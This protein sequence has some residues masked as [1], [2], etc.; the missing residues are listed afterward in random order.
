MSSPQ[1]G[2]R[3]PQVPG[4]PQAHTYQQYLAQKQAYAQMSKQASPATVWVDRA[5]TSV[6]Q[7]RCKCSVA[8]DA[9]V[10]TLLFAMPLSVTRR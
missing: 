10:A 9:A 1:S 2:Q 8:R 4:Y 5:K 6:Q 3:I 7:R